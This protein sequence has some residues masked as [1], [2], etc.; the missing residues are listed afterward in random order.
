V[1][2]RKG[3]NR[4]YYDAIKKQRAGCSTEQAPVAFHFS[5]L[6]AKKGEESIIVFY[7]V[8]ASIHLHSLPILLTIALLHILTARSNLKLADSA[9]CILMIVASV[10]YFQPL[11]GLQG[12]GLSAHG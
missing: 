5:C 2:L 3:A 9:S 7:S 10:A 12:V 6:V 4:N 11:P 8:L 1:G